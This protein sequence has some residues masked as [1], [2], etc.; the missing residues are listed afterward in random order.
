MMETIAGSSAVIFAASASKKGG[1]PQAV[2]YQGLVNVANA[3]IENK[4]LPDIPELAHELHECV[5]GA[6]HVTDQEAGGRQ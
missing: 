3:C 4:V 6:C 2:D 1:D 5:S